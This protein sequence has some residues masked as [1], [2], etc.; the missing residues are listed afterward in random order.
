MNGGIN[1]FGKLYI[2][3]WCLCVGVLVLPRLFALPSLIKDF[4][5]EPPTVLFV[6]L[7]GIAVLIM[8]CKR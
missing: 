7:S 5:N 6:I 2:I 8:V 1:K 4:I 3:F